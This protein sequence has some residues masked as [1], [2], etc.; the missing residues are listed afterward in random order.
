M[1]FIARADTAAVRR[2]V[3]AGGM[4][5]ACG[6]QSWLLWRFGLGAPIPPFGQFW[7]GASFVLLGLAIGATAQWASWL[8]RAPVLALLFSVPTL[9]G[10]HALGLRGAAYAALILAA[11]MAAALLIG[12]LG[13]AIFPPRRGSRQSSTRPSGEC[14][15]SMRRRLVEAKTELDRLDRER[16]HR[17]DIGFGK[18]TEDRIIWAELLDLELQDIDER[19]HRICGTA[20]QD[21]SRP[22]SSSR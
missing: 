5:V 6:Y 2:T 10:A 15:T 14:N 8:W 21:A 1:E 19:L 11:Q 3:V 13:D 22:S 20:G 12:F 9:Y 17:G 7:I 16:E 18:R 4:G